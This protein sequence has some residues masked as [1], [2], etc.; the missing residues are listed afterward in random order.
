MA[1]IL[2]NQNHQVTIVD[3]GS[4]YLPVLDWYEKQK[5]IQVIKLNMN[6]GHTSPWKYN[7]VDRSNFYAVTDP[8]LDISEVPN[9]WDS[10]LINGINKYR[11][12]KAGF[13]LSGK[14]I[15]EGNP[16]WILD[17]F[18]RYPDGYHPTTWGKNIKLCDNFF[19]FP[20]DT[21]FAVYSPGSSYFIGGIRS[22]EPYTA[23]HLPW[24]IVLDAD[25]KS[26]SF[27]IKMN[28]EIYFYFKNASDSSVTKRRLIDMMNQYEKLNIKNQ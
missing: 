13:S 10:L 22:N 20:I 16:A 26:D 18:F 25:K 28:D 14:N 2:L 15:P 19:N 11:C 1:E 27:Q 5:D 24:H 4:T 9:D 17:E 8:D 3:N 6:G 23:K 21:T 12:G 7:I